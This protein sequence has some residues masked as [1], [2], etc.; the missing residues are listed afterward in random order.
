MFIIISDAEN[1]LCNLLDVIKVHYQGSRS[2]L[3]QN[4]T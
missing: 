1:S 4:P 2:N 3:S